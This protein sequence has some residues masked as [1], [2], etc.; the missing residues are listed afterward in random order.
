MS[1][2]SGPAAGAAPAPD[3]PGRPHSIV[4]SAAVLTSVSAVAVALRFYVRAKMLRS[5]KSEDW[6]MLVSMWSYFGTMCYNLSLCFTKISI[7]LLYFRVLTHDYIRKVTWGTMGI[8]VVYNI[9]GFGMYLTMCIPLQKMWHSD[10]DGY[11]HPYEVWWALTYLHIITD[12]MIFLIPIPVVVTM[13]IPLRQKAGLLVVFTLGLF[14]CAISIVRTVWLDLLLHVDDATWYLV[15]IAN[16]STAEV[17]IAIICGC[18]P[19]L[20]PLLTKVFRPLMD[21]I[22]PYHHQS[23]EDPDSTRP[24]TIGSMPLHAFRFG[25]PSNGEDTTAVARSSRLTWTDGRTTLAASEA[26]SN[27]TKLR[28]MESQAELNPSGGDD[29]VVVEP[30]EEPR[31]PQRPDTRD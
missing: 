18:M 28:N 27:Q 13:T 25:R 2:S 23:L 20:K 24:K 4:I 9:W 6:C 17:N 7:L 3:D 11:C 30:D 29:N 19:T 1:S 21:H 14:L 5:V 26:Q 22:L 12:F 31:A 16:W 10:L 15:T 8:V